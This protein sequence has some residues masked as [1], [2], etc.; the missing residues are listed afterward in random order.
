MDLSRYPP[1]QRL[2]INRIYA[3]CFAYVAQQYT[4]DVVVYEANVTPL[5]HLP[6]LRSRWRG[7]APQAQFVGITGTH[8]GMLRE[9][10]VG[11]MARDLGARIA[12]R[13]AST[14]AA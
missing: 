8:L 7:I 1:P 13:A 5:F 9:P 10:F 14:P 3:A 12:A 6:Q 2:F 4:G 11:E